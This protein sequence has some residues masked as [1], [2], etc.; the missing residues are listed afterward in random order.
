MNK[1]ITLGLL[2]SFLTLITII[3]GSVFEPVEGAITPMVP[4][5]VSPSGAAVISYLSVFFKLLTFQVPG[6]PGII[7]GVIFVPITFMVVFMIIDVVKDIIP[8]T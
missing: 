5:S 8:F 7:T 4:S 6:L 3:A 2:V 1:F